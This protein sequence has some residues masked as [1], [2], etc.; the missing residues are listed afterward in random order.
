MRRNLFNQEM[1][2]PSKKAKLP[3]SQ[4][5]SAVEGLKRKRPHASQGE[6]TN[7]SKSVCCK[8]E[9]TDVTC[10]DWTDGE[11]SSRGLESDLTE[12]PFSERHTLL[13][14]QVCETPPH[15]QVS[16]RL[17]QRQKMGR[18]VSQPPALDSL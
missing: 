15:K 8:A 10:S 14:K 17:L 3:R 18:C 13:T 9:L 7:P 11:L 12:Q 1:A 6:N 16:S 5:V 4:S 2:S